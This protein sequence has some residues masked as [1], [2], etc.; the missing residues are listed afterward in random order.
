MAV[1][2]THSVIF[3]MQYQSN[4]VRCWNMRKPFDQ[5]NM[6]VVYQ[7]PTTLYGMQI[8]VDSEGFLWFNKCHIAI[9]LLSGTYSAY[10][11]SYVEE[12]FKW[13]RVQFENLP[14]PANSW[15][16]PYKYY[17]PE[18]IDIMG[19]AYHRSTGI[20]LLALGRLRPGTPTTVA[21]FCTSD[22]ITGS[23]PKFWSFPDWK[24]NEL[25]ASDFDGSSEDESRKQRHKP[26]P[27]KHQIGHEFFKVKVRDAI[28]GTVCED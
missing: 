20:M 17:A 18:N 28:R 5:D 3:Y 22:Y 23:S 11:N 1:D 12:V 25:R 19:M 9:I 4:R 13:K 7:S 16:G 27:S 6:D 14:K 26:S 2:Y 24:T 15:V 21:A 8:F 10:Y